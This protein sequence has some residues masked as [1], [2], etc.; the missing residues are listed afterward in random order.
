MSIAER[1]LSAAESEPQRLAVK[2]K[3]FKLTGRC[4]L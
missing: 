4:Q 2:R 1:L 3:L